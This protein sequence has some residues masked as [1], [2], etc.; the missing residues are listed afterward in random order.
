MEALTLTTC[1]A[2][3]MDFFCQELAGYLCARLGLP[4]TL[5]INLPWPERE[6]RL[7][8]GEIDAGW[9]C[10]LPY[11]WK[12]D[13]TPGRL[14]L[15]AA[16]V[17]AGRRYRDRPVYFSDV[18]VRRDSPFFRLDDLRD[19][20]WA[21]NEPNS[22]SGYNVVRYALAQRGQ[23]FAFFGRVLAAGSHQ[24]ALELILAG[25]ADAAA[26]DSTVLALEVVHRPGLAARLRRIDT[27]GPSPAP[28]WVVSTNLPAALRQALQAA[29]LGMAADPQGQALLRQ[30]DFRRFA[31]VED[32]DYDPIRVME[33]LGRR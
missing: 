2:P 29:L 3:N 17:W 6:R 22:H 12:A 32:R 5:A 16:P 33:R 20:V 30:A 28:P 4:V 1:M 11:V 27:F 26:I 24:A 18:L 14:T 25:Q 8:T 21:Y 13:R 9:I 23:S 10:G 7:D 19:A 31:P 15:L